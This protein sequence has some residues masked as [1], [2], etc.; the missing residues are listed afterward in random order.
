V[1][2]LA[3]SL[4]ALHGAFTGAADPA[5]AASGTAAQAIPYWQAPAVPA[6]V[7]N[8]GAIPAGW[9]P[10]AVPYHGIGPDG[11]PLTIYVAPTYVFTY[12]SG[13][14]VLAVPPA[15]RSVPRPGPV[16]AVG[17]GWNYQTQGA[18]A[19]PVVLQPPASPPR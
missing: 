3:A 11:R 15:T 13:P 14:P 8:G 12:Q 18:A 16:P 10:Q 5:P 9:Q 17:S 4:G 1:A 19:V 6:A 7:V 2:A